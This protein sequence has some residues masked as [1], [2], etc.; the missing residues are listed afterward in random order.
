MSITTHGVWID[1]D[2]QLVREEIRAQSEIFLFEGKTNGYRLFENDTPVPGQ[3]TIIR[4][5]NSQEAAE[6]FI[7]FVNSLDVKPVSYVILPD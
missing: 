5:W 6:E 1:A 3:V 4:R 7:E 2:Y